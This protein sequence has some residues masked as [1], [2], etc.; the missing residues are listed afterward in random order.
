MNFAGTFSGRIDVGGL[1]SGRVIQMKSVVRSEEGNRLECSKC[2]ATEEAQR[3]K[4]I[5]CGGFP[6]DVS[7]AKSKK[8]S[9][10]A[11]QF[12]TELSSRSKGDLFEK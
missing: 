7:E 6:W 9:D 8:K 12:A 4:Y 11:F 5:F 3:I 10:T 2:D 1:R